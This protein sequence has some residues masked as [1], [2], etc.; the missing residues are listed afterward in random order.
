MRIKHYLPVTFLVFL[1]VHVF[2]FRVMA[3]RYPNCKV[4]VGREGMYNV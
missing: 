1:S 2:A 4:Y 3:Q